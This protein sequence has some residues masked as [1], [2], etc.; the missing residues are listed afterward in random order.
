MKKWGFRESEPPGEPEVREIPS[1]WLGGSLALSCPNVIKLSLAVSIPTADKPNWTHR[2]EA[3][4]PRIDWRVLCV[5]G[6]LLREPTQ[7]SLRTLCLCGEYGFGSHCF[8]Q[9]Q[10]P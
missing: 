9:H 7:I 8:A 5:S 1:S 3:D 6:G 2:L 4:A 10:S